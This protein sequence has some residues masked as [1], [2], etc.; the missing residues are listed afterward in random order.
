MLGGASEIVGRAQPR[1]NPWP[2]EVDMPNESTTRGAPRYFLIEGPPDALAKIDDDTAYV[3][4]DGTWEHDSWAARKI[5][6]Y[7]GDADAHPIN[8]EQ[9]HRFVEEEQAEA[10]EVQEGPS[11]GYGDHGAGATIQ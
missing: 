1:P 7:D 5:S 9:A 8:A 11:S 4:R 6:A 10:R 2:K 3:W